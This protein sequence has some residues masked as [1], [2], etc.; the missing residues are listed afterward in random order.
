MLLFPERI[1]IPEIFH[2]EDA[3]APFERCLVCDRS[4]LDG[5]Q[6]YLIEK[7]V[8]QYPEY[9]VRE[10][11]IE[12]ALCLACHA[13]MQNAISE[14]SKLALETYFLENTELHQRA[15]SRMADA[16]TPGESLEEAEAAGDPTSSEA[17]PSGEAPD[18]QNWL[19]RCIV[20][21]T[22]TGDLH[23]F[24]L[25]GHCAGRDMLLTHMPLVIGGPAM[26]EIAQQL[27]NE[28]LDE[29]GGFRDEHFG[30]PPEFS[31][32]IPGPILA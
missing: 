14:A 27:S 12:Y 18:V 8:K 21:G 7:A 20:H 17:G 26:D 3:S 6:E 5:N 30:L 13:E 4:L 25:I 15:F 23:E 9:D 16:A 31:R 29:L 28:T 22:P 11:V 2:S 10:I 24:Q 1:P 19:D 32:D